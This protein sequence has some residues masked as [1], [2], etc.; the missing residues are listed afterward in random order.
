MSEY[1]TNISG[2]SDVFMG[3]VVSYDNAVKQNV[4]KVPEEILK[5]YGAVSEECASFMAKGVKDLMKTDYSVSITGIAGPGGATDAKPVGLVYIGVASKNGV[6]V[7]KNIFN[8]DRQQVRMRS[9][10]KALF[11]LL[12]IIKDN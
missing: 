12:N 3:S 8:G 5:E 7:Y 10:K 1:I 2:A 4:L 6:S 11:Y 9:A